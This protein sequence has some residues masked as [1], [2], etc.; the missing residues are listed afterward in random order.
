MCAITSKLNWNEKLSEYFRAYWTMVRT[1]TGNVR[2]SLVYG[3]EAVIPLEI[4][5]PSLRVALTNMI[6]EG[7][8]DQLCIQKLEALDEKRLQT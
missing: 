4:Q 1:P 8:N 2:F 3:C 5:M 7:D 6:T